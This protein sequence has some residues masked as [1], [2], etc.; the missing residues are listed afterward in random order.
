MRP[1]DRYDVFAFLAAA[2]LI[3]LIATALVVWVW[4]AAGSG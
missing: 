1:I 4:W 2:M 3:L